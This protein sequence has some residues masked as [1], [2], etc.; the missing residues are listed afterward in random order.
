M[1]AAE[2]PDSVHVRQ[3]G[4]TTADD[5]EIWSYAATHDFVIVSKDADFQQRALLTGGPPKVI[6]IRLGNCSTTEAAVLLR[7]YRPAIES[8]A[9]DPAVA[10]LALS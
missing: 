9:A 2:Y 8:F 4:F 1:L 5:W 3:L 10:F 7:A 6:W